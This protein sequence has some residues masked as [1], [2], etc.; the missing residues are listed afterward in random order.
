MSRCAGPSTCRV[1]RRAIRSWCRPAPRRP[2]KRLAARTAEIVFTAQTTLADATAFY[3]DLK[4]RMGAFGRDPAHLKIMPGAFPVV[5]RTEG[6]AQDRDGALQAL[7]HP[8]VG[9]SLLEQLTG[10]DLSAYPNDAPV[11]DLPET[12]G[13]RSRQALILTLARRE[14][15]TI[16]ELSLRIAGARGH[17]TLVGT[18]SRIADALQERFEAYGADGFNIM[19]PT[20]P[21]GLDDFAALVIPE[22]QRRGLFR[23]DYAGRTLRAHLGLPRPPHRVP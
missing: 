15:L 6:E 14:G 5:G 3:A 22:L 19:P 12:E 2:A 21:G 23:T 4:G 11:P 18:A 20:L 9:R 1:P 13:G 7:I 10:A 8:V 16:R 17:W